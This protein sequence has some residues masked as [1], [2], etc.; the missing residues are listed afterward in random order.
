MTSSLGRKATMVGICAVLAGMLAGCHQ[1]HYQA[2]DLYTVFV[3]DLK[4]AQ[5]LYPVPKASEANPPGKPSLKEE[6]ESL[7][8]DEA[9]DQAA[10]ED[11]E[12]ANTASD[13]EADA[14]LQAENPYG[15]IKI[16]QASEN[17]VIY[18][19]Y[20]NRFPERPAQ[21][22]PARL[23]V[24]DPE[25][26]F[27]LTIGADGTHHAVSLP[28]G[29]GHIDRQALKKAPH[30]LVGMGHQPLSEAE[31]ADLNRVN[32]PPEEAPPAAHRRPSPW[33]TPSPQ[34]SAPSGPQE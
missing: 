23:E 31:L 20:S 24:L 17:E 2:G 34:D 29:L 9:A 6:F 5:T 8:F 12:E 33:E 7:F 27:G 4:P 11:D 30:P 19:L 10:G 32:P 28:G 3:A 21:V 18:K 22:D 14:A 13:T 25:V 15:V 16:L 26:G 1:A